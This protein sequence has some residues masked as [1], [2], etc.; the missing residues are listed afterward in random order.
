MKQ[1]ILSYKGFAA[2]SWQLATL[3]HST[4]SL[5]SGRLLVLRDSWSYT[6]RTPTL[7]RKTRSKVSRT[8]RSGGGLR[9]RSPNEAGVDDHW[10]GRCG[11]QLQVVPV[12]LW[13]AG[14]ASHP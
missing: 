10:G 11:C 6:T 1:G 4:Q 3:T 13:P 9:R 7:G 2:S 5:A 8:G 14:D 12:A